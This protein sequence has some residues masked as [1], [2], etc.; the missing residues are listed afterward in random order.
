MPRFPLCPPAALIST[1]AQAEMAVLEPQE[2]V[3]G[4]EMCA[5][6][7]DLQSR[8]QIPLGGQLLSS[9][10]TRKPGLYQKWLNLTPANNAPSQPPSQQTGSRGWIKILSSAAVAALSSFQKTLLLTGNTAAAERR[11]ESRVRGP[12]VETWMTKASE[13]RD[14]GTQ[15]SIA[16]EETRLGHLCLPGLHPRFV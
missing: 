12:G 1:P 8:Q 3:A 15:Q 4:G 10:V 16:G 13:S 14:P 11:E 9:D 7:R 6:A 5:W 2:V